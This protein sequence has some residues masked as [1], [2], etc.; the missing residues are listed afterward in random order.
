MIRI[1][2]GKSIYFIGKIR[3]VK[4]QL[5]CIKDKHMTVVDYIRLQSANYKNSLN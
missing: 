5:A 3:E 4:Q 1:I 2:D